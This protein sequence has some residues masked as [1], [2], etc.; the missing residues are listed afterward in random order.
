MRYGDIMRPLCVSRLQLSDEMRL[1]PTIAAYID[2]LD[3]AARAEKVSDPGTWTPEERDAYG[4]GKWQEF[5]RLRGYTDA[6]IQD[7]QLYLDLT[8]SLI[9]KYGEDDVCWIGY[10]HQEQTG[11][12]GVTP[13]QI[14]QD[15][16]HR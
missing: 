9:A 12:L 1:D 14:L 16:A 7:F 11:I 3:R 4:N 6:E 2:V 15:A 10:T 5:S 8:Y 13:Q